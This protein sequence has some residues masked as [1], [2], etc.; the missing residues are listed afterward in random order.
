MAKEKVEKKEV[1][2]VKEKKAKGPSKSRITCVKCGDAKAVRPEVLEKRIAK[3]HELK[4]DFKK[5]CWA[6]KPLLF[7]EYLTSEIY[8]KKHKD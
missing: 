6:F 1:K 7:G 2:D 5:E 4:K 3:A 8:L